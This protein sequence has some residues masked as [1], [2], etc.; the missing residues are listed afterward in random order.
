MMSPTARA[1]L[2]ILLRCWAVSIATAILCFEVLE[3]HWLIS[4]VAILAMN[5]IWQQIERL[6]FM[7][8]MR[9]ARAEETSGTQ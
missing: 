9:R 8:R 6:L 3:L 7:R 5:F 1:G 4:I 2:V